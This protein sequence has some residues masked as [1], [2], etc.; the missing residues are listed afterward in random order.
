VLHGNATRARTPLFVVF[1]FFL[2]TQDHV[3]NGAQF[4][5]ISKL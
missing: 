5:P 2:L 4:P 1:F 3:K